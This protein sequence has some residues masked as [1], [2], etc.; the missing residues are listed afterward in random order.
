MEGPTLEKARRC[1]TEERVLGTKSSPLV[2][3]MQGVS[4]RGWTA[5]VVSRVRRGTAKKAPTDKSSVL[6]RRSEKQEANV[7]DLE[8][9]QKHT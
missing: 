3:D 7:K 4:V 2:E 5:E 8:R 1:L 6:N 9:R